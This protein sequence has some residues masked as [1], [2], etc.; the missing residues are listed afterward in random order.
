VYLSRLTLQNYR[1]YT[2]LDLCLAPGT[3]VFLGANAQGKTNLL[4]SIYL[5]ATLRAPRSRSDLDLIRSDA[6]DTE[7]PAARIGA[8]A[9]RRRGEVDVMIAIGAGTGG[10]GHGSKRLLVNGVPRR[11][12]EVIGQIAAVLFTAQDMDIVTGPPALRRRYLDVTLS[13]ANPPYLR[14]LQR[15]GRVLLQRNTLLRRIHEGAAKADQLDFWDHELVNGTA[16][17][18]TVRCQ[19]VSWLN[20]Q[21]ATMHDRLSDGAEQLRIAYQPQLP[22][23]LTSESLELPLPELQARLLESLRTSQRREIEAGAS[24]YGPHRD[25][26]AFTVDNAH[27]AAFGS[28]AQQRTAALSLR[29]AEVGYIEAECGDKPVLLLDDILSELD[30]GRRRAIV[31]ALRDVDQILIT[32]TEADRFG[33]DFLGRVSRYRVSAGRVDAEV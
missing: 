6:L 25:D 26:L 32:A 11:A 15:Y 10:Q 27:L 33:T 13:Q 20:R 16:S 1:N 18:A 23:P 21:A 17:I 12:S 22:A 2:S 19:A 5:L 24:L 31:D 7:L 4:E 28:R 30:E 29:L 8:T 9:Q 3:T 14:A